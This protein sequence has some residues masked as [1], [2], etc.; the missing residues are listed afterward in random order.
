MTRRNWD[1]EPK[2]ET[3][4]DQGTAL[5]AGNSANRDGAQDSSRGMGQKNGRASSKI[6]HGAPA[7]DGSNVRT[8]TLGQIPM[9]D[10]RRE[11]DSYAT[12]WEKQF[13]R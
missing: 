10:G 11:A 7:S 3:N 13:S 4:F 6:R 2:K 1:T 5:K 9:H 8:N 12:P